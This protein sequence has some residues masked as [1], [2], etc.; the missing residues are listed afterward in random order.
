MRNSHTSSPRT[1]FL[2]VARRTQPA[3]LYQDFFALKDMTCSTAAV[4]PNG[5]VEV[6]FDDDKTTSISFTV[7][8]HGDAMLLFE[9]V[10]A[11]PITLSEIRM[12]FGA[13]NEFDASKLMA[14][15]KS[16]SFGAVDADGT[17]A[18]ERCTHTSL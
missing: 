9:C 7:P 12:T 15:Q 1:P 2:L 6:L 14:L 8:K 4:A 17:E 18:C 5:D 11:A 13:D 16:V 3:D 10:L